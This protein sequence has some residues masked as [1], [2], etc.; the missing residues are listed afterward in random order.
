MGHLVLRLRGGMQIFVKTLS[1]N[2]MVSNKL[3]LL[4]QL[5][6]EC[7]N[8]PS[9][10]LFRHLHLEPPEIRKIAFLFPSLDFL[11]PR[12]LSPLC[13]DVIGGVL[14]PDR[15]TTSTVWNLHSDVRDV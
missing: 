4:L 5:S 2:A 11:G 13:V 3:L 10:L 1:I 12:G 6:N 15:S 7:F 9:P 14:F 8:L